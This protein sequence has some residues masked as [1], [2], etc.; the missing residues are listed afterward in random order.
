M[1]FVLFVLIC[2]KKFICSISR[3]MGIRWRS[4]SE[5][6]FLPL[7]VREGGFSGKW[8]KIVSS[9]P[10]YYM[11]TSQVPMDTSSLIRYQFDVEIPVGKWIHVEIKTSIRRGLDFQNRRNIDFERCT[12]A[13]GFFYVV[14][15]SNRR[16]FCTRYFH[17][18]I[19]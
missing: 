8:G 19:F 7:G 5:Q 1:R 3:Q 15:T 13:R 17:S 6:C 18:I 10:S 2:Q 9:F 11:F 4:L 16:N 12:I 14:S